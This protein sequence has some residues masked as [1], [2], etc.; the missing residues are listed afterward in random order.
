MRN[1]WS[2]K[3]LIVVLV[4]LVAAISGLAYDHAR[5]S[6]LQDEV[7]SF[8]SQLTSLEGQLASAKAQSSSL[9][10]EVT[11]G[12]SQISS[13]TSQVSA[14]TGQTTALQGQISSDNAQIARL[15][16]Q[17]ASL[18]K[19][20]GDLQN[21]IKL[22][23]TVNKLNAVTLNQG[24][25]QSSLVTAF[26][27]DYAGYVIVTGTSTSANGYVMVADSYPGYPYNSYQYA[28][29]TG[30]TVLV[31]V[32]PGLVQVYFGNTNFYNGTTA[33]LTVNYCY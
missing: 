12:K 17:V 20:N 6:S 16:E 3:T 26:T 10:S 30:N 13:L 18:Q 31:P 14:L 33:T 2:A 29:G 9:Q 24:A 25:N 7:S 5:A 27:A 28:F 19:Q 21:I 22:S 4:A 11:S 32:L 15:Q 1:I 8:S 23:V